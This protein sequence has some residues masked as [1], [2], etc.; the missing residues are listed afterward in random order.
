MPIDDVET[1]DRYRPGGYH[2]VT[3]G[4]QLGGRYSLVHRLGFGSYSTIW[5]AR[6]QDAGR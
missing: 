6:N 1:L 3:V 2:P 5:L 4:E